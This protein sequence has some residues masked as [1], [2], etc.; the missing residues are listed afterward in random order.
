MLWVCVF[1]S[2]KARKDFSDLPLSSRVYLRFV[3]IIHQKVAKDASS[4]VSDLKV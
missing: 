1:W 3:K 2:E 4:S